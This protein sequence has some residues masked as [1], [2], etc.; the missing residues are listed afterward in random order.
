MSHMVKLIFKAYEK[1]DEIFFI[2]FFLYIKMLT[3]YYQ[4]TKKGFQKKLVK[5]T[6]I[7]LKKKTK[8]TNM[9]L[10][11]MEIFLKKKKKKKCPYDHERYK[12]LLKH[13]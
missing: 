13:E 4:K 11:Y 6:K 2:I 10:S 8:S 5:S 3:G 12:N 1:S 7:F 9:L